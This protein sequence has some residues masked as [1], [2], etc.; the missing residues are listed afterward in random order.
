MTS[1]TEGAKR[2]I[3]FI[4]SLALAIKQ[5]SVNENLNANA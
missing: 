2:V 1:T 4:A 5:L 3:Q